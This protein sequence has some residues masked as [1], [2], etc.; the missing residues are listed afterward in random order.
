MIQVIYE[1]LRNMIPENTMDNRAV[2]TLAEGVFRALLREGWA[3]AHYSGPEANFV[4]E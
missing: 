2:Y 4:K 3:M 1:S